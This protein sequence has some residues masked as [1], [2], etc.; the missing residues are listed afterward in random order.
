M[1]KLFEKQNQDCKNCKRLEKI[2]REKIYYGSDLN[3]FIHK[4]C[5][6]KMTCINIDCLIYRAS[7]G[8]IRI[9]ESKHSNEIIGSGQKTVLSLLA[10]YFGYLN[11]WQNKIKF[12]VY[13]VIGNY[14]YD[15]IKV[16]NLIS[17]EESEYSGEDVIKFLELDF[18]E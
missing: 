12:E 16:H 3:K 15:S 8:H 1:E 6:K 4:N 10:R 17:G 14:P 11:K 5:S 7:K 9:I 13:Y 18:P 2:I